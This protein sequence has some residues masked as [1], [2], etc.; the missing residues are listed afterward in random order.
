MANY[1][2]TG[3]V[4]LEGCTNLD[5]NFL[6]TTTT[7]RPLHLRTLPSHAFEAEI[8]PRGN[9]THASRAPFSSLVGFYKIQISDSLMGAMD[10]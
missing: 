7:A 8:L 9:G 1:F 5:P 3:N 6:I 2:V 10:L 4:H